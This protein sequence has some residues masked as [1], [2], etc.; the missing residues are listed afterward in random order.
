MGGGTRKDPYVDEEVGRLAGVEKAGADQVRLGRSLGEND[1]VAGL[2]VEDV[3]DSC[4]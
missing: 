2:A 1:V 4:R 3:E